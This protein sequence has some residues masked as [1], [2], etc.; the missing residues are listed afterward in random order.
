MRGEANRQTTML[1][2][3]TPE[4]RVPADHPVRRIKV[5]ADAALAELSGLLSTMY[6]DTGRPSIA[7]ERLLKASLLMAFYSVRSDRL[8][9]EQ[10][11]YNLLF[12][13]FLDMNGDEPS[14]DHSSFT[15]NRGRLLDH[16]VARQFF[17]L[18][19]EQARSLGLVSDEHFSVDGSLIE[20]WASLKSFQPKESAV[21]RSPHD[22]DPG[23]P[24]VDF[25][26]ERRSNQSHQS[27]TDPEARLAKKGKGKEAKLCY[28]LNHLME[29]RN[30]LP[31]DTRVAIVTG[32][33][34]RE[35]G[36]MMLRDLAPGKRRTVAGD[37]GF[38]TAGFV[39]GCREL[40]VTAHVAQNSRR[41]QGSAIDGRTTHWPGYELSQRA[42]KRIEEIFG[43][44]KTVGNFRKTRFI[45]RLKTQLWA[46]LEGT[47][48]NLM[49]IAKLCPA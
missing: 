13:W 11:D 4:Q 19:V 14:F 26:G 7:P 36:L 47:A 32:A 22:D 5:L 30:G 43:W 29:N 27:T 6:S 12:R 18:I 21:Q 38:D 17:K 24:S 34:E 46:Y 10:L 28:S 31:V 25:H 39:A 3:R 37:K 16:D 8:F 33:E 40:A 2:L 35:Q 44:N 45:G 48:Y 49:R 23:N 41:P 20:A 42:R 15:H 1:S 9:C